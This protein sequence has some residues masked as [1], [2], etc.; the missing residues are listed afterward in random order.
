M[1]L[2]AGTRLG[3]CEILSGVGAAGV[4]QPHKGPRYHT[5]LDRTVAP[6]FMVRT[7]PTSL[8]VATRARLSR[9]RLRTLDKKGLASRAADIGVP[10]AA[11]RHRKHCAHAIVEPFAIGGA[12]WDGSGAQIRQARTRPSDCRGRELL[13]AWGVSQGLCVIHLER[14]A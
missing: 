12:A 6:K 8:G 10:S 7:W 2:A 3:P 13:H 1:S 4:R 14:P 9:Q 11:R 5:S